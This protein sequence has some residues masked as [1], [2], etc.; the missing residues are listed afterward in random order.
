MSIDQDDSLKTI[1]ALIKQL[2]AT[3]IG[4][5]QVRGYVQG[6]GRHMLDELID[7][8]ETKLAEIKRKVPTE[9]PK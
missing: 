8:G 1:L 9:G 4:L 3:L 2:E 5:K 6:V 7:E